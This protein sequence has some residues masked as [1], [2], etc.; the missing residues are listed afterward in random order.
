MMPS[1]RSQEGT[2]TR[3]TAFDRPPT[4]GISHMPE[5]YNYSAY[6]YERYPP[7]VVESSTSLAVP[8]RHDTEALARLPYQPNGFNTLKTGYPLP[9]PPSHF[10]PPTDKE[11]E[12][13]AKRKAEEQEFDRRRRE[14]RMATDP[15]LR[16]KYDAA[17]RF[18]ERTDLPTNMDTRPRPDRLQQQPTPWTGKAHHRRPEADPQFTAHSMSDWKDGDIPTPAAPRLQERRVIPA[19]GRRSHNQSR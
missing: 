1:A 18:L 17:V 11:M 6:P 10:V 13:D 8:T 15:A 12:D 2:V 14:E 3:A 7:E 4:G 5:G 9:A 16:A 19:A